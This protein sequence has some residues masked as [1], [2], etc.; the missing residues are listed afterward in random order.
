MVTWEDWSS[1]IHFNHNNKKFKELQEYLRSK[2][3][4]ISKVLNLLGFE[5]VRK[6]SVF[7]LKEGLMRLWSKLS[8]EEALLLSKFIAQEK[9]EIEVERIIDSLNI[10]DNQP[11]EV[12]S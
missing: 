6:V 4:T 10:S 8:D 12:D 1:N 2:K 3:Y 11:V 5:G 9:E 7:T